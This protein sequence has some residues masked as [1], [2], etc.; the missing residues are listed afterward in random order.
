MIL[1]LSCGAL[2][3]AEQPSSDSLIPD[4]ALDESMNM[5][6]SGQAAFVP[7]FGGWFTPVFL[8]ETR[9]AYDLVSSM[10]TL[11]LW[12]RM[13]L[14]GNS[15]VYARVRDS[16]TAVISKT[17]L[18]TKSSNDLDIDSC[19]VALATA[20]RLLALDVGRK[21]FSVGSGLVVN[22]RGDGMELALTSSF[23]DV[24]IFG[25]YTGL[26]DKD[27]NPYGLSDRDFSDGAKRMFAGSTFEKSFANQTAY[28]FFV[29]QRDYGK[30]GTGT[31]SAGN[32]VSIKSRYG[33]R[34]FGLGVKGDL[35][36][37]IDYYAEG[38]YESG[39]SYAQSDDMKK[40]DISAYAAVAGVNWY[41]DLPKKPSISLQYGYGS[42]DA[43][44]TGTTSAT[45][46]QRGKDTGFV[47]FGTFNSGYS[48]RPALSNIHLFR[49]GPSFMPFAS[50]T[51]IAREMSF[52][53]RYD[54]Y[55]RATKGA[56][57]NSEQLSSNTSSRYVGQGADVIYRWSPFKD[58][59][60]FVNY[61]LFV[62]GSALESSES[63]RHFVTAG[64]NI[65]F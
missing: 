20:N 63:M 65:V 59:A 32:S 4:L 62:P 29:S 1:L 30:Q 47:S 27:S 7:S 53:I 25:F 60:F 42:G 2:S 58:L 22:G 8:S 51:G 56:V 43:D 57:G 55:L 39:Y 38:V 40:T 50:S 15:F 17:N 46:N 26:I 10:N 14:G 19:Y 64:M 23:V 16:Y 31:D 6:P 34:Y 52:G 3:A 54:L 41:I 13:S 21:F 24:S 61:G 44:R 28:C 37:G 49:G 5:A 33:S 48:F 45:G 9:K 18:T 11:R 35:S 36:Y 12:G